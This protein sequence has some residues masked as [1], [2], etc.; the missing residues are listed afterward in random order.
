MSRDAIDEIKRRLDL[1]T[2]VAETTQLKGSGAQRLGLCPFHGDKHPSLSVTSQVWVCRAGSCARGGDALTWL[3]ELG[4]SFHDALVE[5]AGRTGV[6]LPER[7]GPP[8]PSR[9][10]L[11][12]LAAAT[13]WAATWYRS[14]LSTT[15][16]DY[17]A[18][19]RISAEVID[20]FGL[21][22]APP[23]VPGDKRWTHLTDAAGAHLEA[24][25]ALGLS[26]PTTKDPS[27]FID[28]LRSRL[29]CPIR[30]LSGRVVGFSGRD[31]SGRA[32]APK[33]VNSRESALFRKGGE[34]FG[35]YEARRAIKTEQRAI[36]V[37]GNVDVL[38][39]HS[40]GL[41]CTVAPCGTAF[42]TDQA[43]QIARAVGPA[44]QV[45][46]IP[47]G[48]RAGR[49]ALTTWLPELLVH[50]VDVMVCEL[51]DGQDPADLWCTGGREAID[52]VLVNA[53]AGV[54]VLVRALCPTGAT[55]TP[56][57][58]T[59]LAREL[60]PMLARCTAPMRQ[61][62]FEAAARHVGVSPNDFEAWVLDGTDSDPGERA[63]GKKPEIVVAAGQLE[64]YTRQAALALK[65]RHPT[66]FSR[67]KMVV[68]V[69]P[70]GTI[71]AVDVAELAP[72]L[73]GSAT[74][75]KEMVDRRSREVTRNRSDVP[76]RTVTA[77]A[78][79]SD[80]DVLQT[81]DA[82]VDVPYLR[83]SMDVVST[84]GYDPATRIL[85]V[86]KARMAQVLDTPTG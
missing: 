14:Q 3:M 50:D 69:D 36:V 45:L 24:V 40:A 80:R 13:T 79:G 7:R 9:D 52:D 1:R 73:E 23:T 76:A 25:K 61:A 82:V 29:I 66:I 5:L 63:D 72:L 71:H 58:K 68:R 35:L 41:T 56:A 86:G 37:E 38:A 31:L 60:R 4:W 51:P 19:R 12:K 55:S 57:A 48:D 75:V 16:R 84:P 78:A 39:M 47:D 59:K 67:A 70:A 27:R 85:P 77:I 6:E 22:E 11:G 83:P 15:G 43:A 34:L 64:A 81:L 74:W 26:V 20:T 44:G 17:L 10:D 30:N 32:D 46:V 49:T 62:T 65:A 42:T 54:E 18:R 21:G 33:Y 28:A 8:G 53:Q 2:L